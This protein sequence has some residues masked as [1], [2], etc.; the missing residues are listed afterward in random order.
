M[1]VNNNTKYIW[2]TSAY[3]NTRSL[4]WIGSETKNLGF[5][6]KV[7]TKLSL[8][9]NHELGVD[10]IWRILDNKTSKSSV[11]MDQAGHNIKNSFNYNILYETRDNIHLP[12]KGYFARFGLEVSGLTP[13]STNNFIKSVVEAQATRKITE[14]HSLILTN[15]FGMI[16]SSENSFILDRFLWGDPMMLD[17]FF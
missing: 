15:K 17:H 14:S 9:I 13:F 11:I 4:E 2:D 16:N 7:M 1:P 6:S 8:G 12:S 5:S 10:G 3:V